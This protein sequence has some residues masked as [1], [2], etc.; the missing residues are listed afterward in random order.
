MTRL[1]PA[2]RWLQSLKIR[3][4]KGVTLGVRG[5][6][7]REGKVFLVRHTYV[8]GWYLPGGAVEP[9]ES[10]AVSLSRE[11]REEGNIEAPAGAMKLLSLTFNPQVAGRDHVATYIVTEFTQGAL[12]APNAEIAEVGWFALDALPQPMNP[13]SER[14]LNEYLTGQD[15][16]DGW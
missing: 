5:L 6:V 8:K 11:L 13:G 15:L 12:P 4:T 10:A 16:S 7:V 1:E 14:R 9:F 2:V 3:L